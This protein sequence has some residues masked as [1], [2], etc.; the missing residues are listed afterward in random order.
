MNKHI[1]ANGILSAR[2][3]TSTPQLVATLLAL[4]PQF[5]D[6]QWGNKTD[7][8]PPYKESCKKPSPKIAEKRKR[9]RE[10]S[11]ASKKRNRR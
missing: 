8:E 9:A 7:P 5:L 10:I 1:Q 11:N 3:M 6:V 4:D 2:V